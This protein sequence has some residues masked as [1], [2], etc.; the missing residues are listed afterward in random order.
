MNKGLQRSAGLVLIAA[1]IAL[2]IWLVIGAPHLGMGLGKV[3]AHL[4]AWGAVFAGG[5]LTFWQSKG[6]ASGETAGDRT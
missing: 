6:D 3:V 1:G 2:A 4:V 5:G